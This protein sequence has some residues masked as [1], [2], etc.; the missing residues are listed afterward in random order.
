MTAS[1]FHQ[2]KRGGRSERG[3]GGLQTCGDARRTG[4]L[5]GG[6]QDPRSSTYSVQRDPDEDGFTA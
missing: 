1:G 5:S 2:A 4:L 3:G 6:G